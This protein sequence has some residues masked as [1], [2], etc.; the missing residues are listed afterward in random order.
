MEN[1]VVA[2][3]VIVV[4]GAAIALAWKH[5]VAM[6]QSRAKVVTADELKKAARKIVT[7]KETGNKHEVRRIGVSEMADMGGA[8]SLAVDIKRKHERKEVASEEDLN[9]MLKFRNQLICRGVTSLKA[10]MCERDDV[11]EGAIHVEDLPPGDKAQLMNE[12]LSFSEFSI[13]AAKALRP[14]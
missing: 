7:M 6:V 3:L 11:P 9:R 1:I 12:I 4:A 13:E 8:I 2:V 14:S 5:L 10:V